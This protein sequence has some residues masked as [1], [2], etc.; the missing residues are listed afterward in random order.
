MQNEINS[1]CPGNWT[2]NGTLILRQPF[3]EHLNAQGQIPDPSLPVTFIN[4]TAT[5]PIISAILPNG[6]NDG[7]TKSVIIEAFD[8]SFTL[9]LNGYNINGDLINSVLFNNAGQSIHLVWN[10]VTELWYLLPT[11]ASIL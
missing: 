1:G 5:F 10:S 8:T 6:L 4:T 3:A 7:Y 2:V 11:G 9:Y